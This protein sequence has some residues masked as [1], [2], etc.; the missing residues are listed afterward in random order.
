[1]SLPISSVYP[2]CAGRLAHPG[3]FLLASCSGIGRRI[4]ALSP[5]QNRAY[6][7]PSTRLPGQVTRVIYWQGRACTPGGSVYSPEEPYLTFAAV[8]LCSSPSG[9]WSPVPRQPPFRVSLSAHAALSSRLCIPV[10]F[11]LLAVAS[12]DIFSSWGVVPS[13]R[14]AYCPPGPLLCLRQTPRGFPRSPS[15]ECGRGGCSLCAGAWCPR[16]ALSRTLC[17]GPNHRLYHPSS[18]E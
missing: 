7:S 10:A 5:P 12:W 8:G 3:W 2:C 1:M 11:R 6:P 16:R 14:L 9:A 4:A 13:L 18:G 17:L 15:I